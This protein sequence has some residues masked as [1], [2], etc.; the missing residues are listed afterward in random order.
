MFREKFQ[1]DKFSL[2]STQHFYI[3]DIISLV[4]AN[5]KLILELSLD[6]AE[7]YVGHEDVCIYIT[8][9]D[10][11]LRHICANS[12]DQPLYKFAS[13][14]LNTTLEFSVSDEKTDILVRF[15][16]KLPAD[17]FDSWKT[18][19]MTGLFITWYFVN[20]EVFT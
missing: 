18:K 12:R 3:K 6:L 1:E 9:V 8:N 10:L 16:R 7:D 19:R 17:K 13:V 11:S 4:S 14:T 5:N 20:T 15:E 2:H